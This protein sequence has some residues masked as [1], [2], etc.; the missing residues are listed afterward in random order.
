MVR[1]LHIFSTFVYCQM[2]L[3]VQ[4]MKQQFYHIF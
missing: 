4:G 3:E 2:N 1:K